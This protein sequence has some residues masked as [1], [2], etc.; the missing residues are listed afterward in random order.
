MIDIN[1]DFA[2]KTIDDVV[3]NAPA[4]Q[5]FL[6][7]KE[8]P[9]VVLFRGPWGCGKNLLA[10]LFAQKLPNT[11]IT[12]RDT[13][14]STAKSAEEIIEQLSSPPFLPINRVCILDEFH[15]F[16]KDAQRKFLHLFQAPPKNVYLFVCTIDADRIIPDIINRFQLVISVGKLSDAESFD[17]VSR[18]A[19]KCKIDL[20]KV[21]R[22]LIASASK[23]VPRTIVLTVAALKNMSEIN[24]EV[25]QT[26]VKQSS[27]K[28]EVDVL[29]IYKY[30]MSGMPGVVEG[31]RQRIE[32]SKADPYTIRMQLLALAY[33]EIGRNEKARVLLKALVKPLEE[34]VEKY[35]LMSRL[36]SYR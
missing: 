25:I 9:Q 7:M 11:E 10:F 2:G 20:P 22:N 19:T 23:G 3:G 26:L 36:I 13:A 6:T 8:V 27:Y 14:D 24:E 28:E 16:R 5:L 32:A 21:H 1:R 4:R 35:D 33:L 34:Q 29:E 17:L 15:M 12:I 30:L 18:E 31:L